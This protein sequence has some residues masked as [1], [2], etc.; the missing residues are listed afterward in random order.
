MKYC[1]L[2][3][4]SFLLGCVDLTSSTYK[5]H[6]NKKELAILGIYGNS[7]NSEIEKQFHQ[8]FAPFKQPLSF[9]FINDEL[10]VS[11]NKDAIKTFEYVSQTMINHSS[12]IILKGYILDPI[13]KERFSFSHTLKSFEHEVFQSEHYQYEFTPHLSKFE[14]KLRLDFSYGC[15]KEKQPG[16]YSFLVTFDELFENGQSSKSYIENTKLMPA[17]NG[18]FELCITV[19]WQINN[20]HIL[21]T[22][23]NHHRISPGKEIVVM[24]IFNIEQVLS[25]T[26]NMANYLTEMGLDL[27]TDDSIL[28]SHQT[29][30]IL[31]LSNTDNCQ[32]FKEIFQPLCGFPIKTTKVKSS[33]EK[34]NKTLSNFP[35]PTTTGYLSS[36]SFSFDDDENIWQDF[37]FDCIQKSFIESNPTEVLMTIEIKDED[38]AEEHEFS[39]KK[40]FQL[41]YKNHKSESKEL[42]EDYKL[43][44]SLSDGTSTN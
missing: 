36:F 13:I 17:F 40:D 10:L 8:F 26:G 24:P 14:Q 4:L 2:F 6:F 42:N 12:K 28:I 38:F 30:N 29:S 43:S 9:T 35:I 11:G 22:L 34:N 23:T 21:R 32:R 1:S 27:S 20:C 37:N 44:L 5:Y 33:L 39:L 16:V 15:T 3:L 19:S 31:L 25:I 18:R 41:F 7:S